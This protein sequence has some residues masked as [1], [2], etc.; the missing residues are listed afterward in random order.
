MAALDETFEL[1]K[2][3]QPSNSFAPL[4]EGWY[5]AT[6]TGAEVKATKS[7]TGKYIAIRFDITGPTHQGRLFFANINIRNA[8]PA[9]EKIG[10]EQFAA[11]MLAGGLATVTDSDQLVGASMKIDLGI[12]HS[13]AYGDKNRVKSFKALSGA[14]P[15]DASKSAKSG[16]APPW[17]TK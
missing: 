13:E 5:E 7:G 3:S 8:N 17:T 4:P 16:S 14:M 10:K 2:M 11:I 1:S 6:I 9:A 12:E 15:S